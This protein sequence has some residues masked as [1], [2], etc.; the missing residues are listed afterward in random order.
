MVYKV[1]RVY[2]GIIR[3]FRGRWKLIQYFDKPIIQNEILAWN[4][5]WKAN[6]FH[7]EQHINRVFHR[8]ANLPNLIPFSF[9]P[10]R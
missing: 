3:A 6:G 10:N 9:P 8:E 5:T 2:W 7:G 1:R 4:M